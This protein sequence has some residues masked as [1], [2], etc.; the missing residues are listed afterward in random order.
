MRLA[1]AVDEAQPMRA[2]LM[3]DGLDDVVPPQRAVARLKSFWVIPCGL[4]VELLTRRLRYSPR[5]VVVR[6][7]R[8]PRVK[9][10]VSGL[11]VCPGVTSS[12]RVISNP[13]T[14]KTNCIS[15]AA[16]ICRIAIP[17]ESTP[18]LGSGY[19]TLE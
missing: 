6:I 17:S 4:T 12:E 13:S 19:T 9:L 15:P 8:Y 1:V 7:L 16:D 3:V 10:L 11:S 18:G 14:I 2:L 5:L